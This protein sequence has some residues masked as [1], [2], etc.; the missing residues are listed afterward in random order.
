[1][2]RPLLNGQHDAVIVWH[3]LNIQ[4]GGITVDEPG[5]RKK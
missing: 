3:E 2:I 4:A 5:Q 1:M